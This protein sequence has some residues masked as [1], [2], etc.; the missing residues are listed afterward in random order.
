MASVEKGLFV[1]KSSCAYSIISGELVPQMTLNNFESE[2]DEW[3][4]TEL[5]Q[6]YAKLLS[7]EELFDN[8]NPAIWRIGHK[9][10]GVG[11]CVSVIVMLLLM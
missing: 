10:E 8:T 6:L 3:T 9:T 5:I 7:G 11:V 1:K 2:E 4:W